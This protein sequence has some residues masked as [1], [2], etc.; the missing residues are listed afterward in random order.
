[1][2]LGTE[3]E[4]SIEGLKCIIKAMQEL[5]DNYDSTSEGAR[6]KQVDKA[7]LKN[8][9]YNNETTFTFEKYVTKLKGVLNVLEKYG[10]MVYENQMVDH[11]LEQIMSP[12]TEL[13]TEFN[14]I[15]SSHSSTSIKASNYLYT[16]VF[17]TIF[18]YQ[19]FIRPLQKAH[20]L[21]YW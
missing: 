18:I 17:R 19:P 6:R 14:I 2:T 8:I 5:Q 20:Y 10:V 7:D 12:N 3:S 13:N 16:V 1:M 4:T 9:F 15:R 21:C 11:L